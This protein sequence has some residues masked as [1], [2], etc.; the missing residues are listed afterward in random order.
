MSTLSPEQWRALAPYLD[1]ALEI[2]EDQRAVWLSALATENP[3]LAAQLAPLLEEHAHLAK[4]GFMDANVTPPPFAEPGLA[5]QV[6]GSYTLLSLIGQGG[7]GSV[8]LAE[9]N[10]GRFQRRVAVKFLNL[11][12][13][14][15]TNEERFKR[16]G[17]ILGRLAHQNIAELVDAGVSS[18]GFPYLVLEYVE[19]DHIDRYCDQHKLDVES[20]IRLFLDVASAVDHAHANLIVHRDLKPSNMLVSNEG[21]VKLLDFGIAKLI[22]IKDSDA[23][24]TALTAPGGQVLTPE[25][26]APEQITGAP[27]TT[28]TDVYALGILLY[29]LLTGEHP[30]GDK[31][32]TPADL[33]KAIV[34][35]EPRRLSDVVTLAKADE[36][37]ATDNAAQRATTPDKLQR[38]LRGDLDTI[39]A[40]ALKK[41]PQERYASMV[42]FAND[43]RRYLQ[44]Q[45]I[46]ARPDT[47]TYR[48]AKFVRRNRVVVGLASLALLA[49][50][51]GVIGVLIQARTA[52]RQR[53]FALEQLKRSEEHDE[54]LNFLLYNAPKGKIFSVA[55][56]LTRAEQ[57]V[58]KQQ[59]SNA[60]RR[61]DLWM[62]LAEDYS[63]QDQPGKARVLAEKAY[64][65]SSGL[66]DPS[67]HARAACV[68]AATL[69]GVGELKRAEELVKEGLHELPDDP[70]HALDRVNCLQTGGDVA[71][72]AGQMQLAI[73]RMETA[74]RVVTESPLAT[75]ALRMRTVADL[76]W[77]YSFAGKNPESLAGY[78]RAAAFLPSL[79]Y[80]DTVT[81]AK[82]FGNWA[83]ELDQIGRT[84]EAEKIEKRAIMSLQEGNN[85]DAVTPNYLIDY[86]KML[87]KLNRLDEASDLAQ[88]AYD[89]GKAG[90]NQVVMGQSLLVL[91]RIAITQ[92]KFD[93]AVVLLSE[94]DPLMRQ[95]LPPGHYAFS[96]LMTDRAML[97]LGQGN[98]TR[99]MDLSKQAVAL[100]E[101]AIAKSKAGSFTFSTVLLNDSRIALAAG[102]PEQALSDADRLLAME[103]SSD[104]EGALSAKAGNA[105]L[106]RARALQAM[107]RH[108]DARAAA[109]VA[110]ERL[111]RSVGPDNPESQSARQ[112]ADLSSANR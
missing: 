20:R 39:V 34:D 36:A 48:A 31:Q 88:Q 11:A 59:S 45:P 37:A 107:G 96:V 40:K 6:I 58:E 44:H 1:Q 27:V 80:E 30:V 12:L 103:Q 64:G 18:A 105:Y 78:E 7:M 53:D 23:A 51:A 70:Q 21:Q 26:A 72:A 61:A 74:E 112:L 52:R 46:S 9:R 111:E 90:E 22:E 95:I 13:V 25:Y 92:T 91:A 43:L 35:T 93:R 102:K 56:L 84:L 87:S 17:A 28:V 24:L 77:A 110:V 106:A 62:W 19:G 79:G 32:K 5:G 49:M 108:N 85:S 63:S 8:W 75:D 65:L 100:G 42:A 38:V 71:Q 98:I 68:L 54:L 81:A 76:A 109:Q 15:R 67:M 66:P 3:A 29:L 99:A 101:A 41:N 55:D 50:F 33:V 89:K 4:A 2:E 10:D 86:S 16:E 69:S 57:V 104:Q 94:L 82:L 47:F 83:V 97:A 14:G 60:A 73:D